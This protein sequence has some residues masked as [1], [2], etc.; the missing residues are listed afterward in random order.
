MLTLLTAVG[1]VAIYTPLKRLTTLNTFIGAFPGALPPLLGWTAARGIIEWPGV[2]LFLILFLWQFPHFMAIGWMYRDDYGRA[3]IR[4]SATNP[5]SRYAARSSVA[6]AV[7]YAPLIFAAS[8]WPFWLGTA[9]LPYAMAACIL[10]GAYLLYSIRFAA[11][12][13]CPDLH[14]ADAPT[15]RRPARDLLHVSVIYLPLLLA[16]M[17]LNTQGRLIL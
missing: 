14:D 13:R 3:G 11:I 4:I 17:M 10:S 16:A 5:D 8:L 15:N 9:G 6:Q 7:F 1:Y 2:A 12:L